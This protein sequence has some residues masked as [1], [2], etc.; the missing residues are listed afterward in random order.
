V[1][2][3]TKSDLNITL[4]A[5][6]PEDLDLLYVWEND[7]S[8][9]HVGNTLVPFSKYQLKQYIASDPSNIFT[10]LQMRLMID[11]RQRASPVG[12]IDLFDFEPI[13][14]R[15]AVGLLIASEKDRRQGYAKNALLQMIEY[16][17][18]ILYLNQI[19][20]NVAASNIP[21]INLFKKLNFNITGTKKEWL[22]TENGWDDE[23]IMQRKVNT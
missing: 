19:Y 18:N 1:Q 7:R 21:C 8:V 2:E 14:K 11:C 12:I 17:R 13:H 22:C 23:L 20:C 4:R 10:H 9:W 5:V 16:C 6:E 3:F 15:A